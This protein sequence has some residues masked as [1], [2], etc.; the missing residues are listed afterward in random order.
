MLQWQQVHE[1]YHIISNFYFN[2]LHNDLVAPMAELLWTLIFSALNCSSSHRYV[3]GPSS[4][5]MWDKILLAGGQVIFLKGSSILAQP[6]DWLG[7][8]W[9]KY[10]WRA[11]KPK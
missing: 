3:F 8:K 4:G 6:L 11:V 5:H 9:V 7:R 1:S 10:S 2:Q